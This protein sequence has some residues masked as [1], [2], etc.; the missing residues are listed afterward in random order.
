MKVLA[1]DT[2]SII[3]GVC[4]VVDDKV[5]SS[6]E[7]G[8]KKQSEEIV[9]TINKVLLDAKIT[10]DDIDLIAVS[11]GPA[12]FTSIRIGLACAKA[13]S[14]A[15][16]IPLI[17]IDSLYAIA[18][19]FEDFSGKIIVLM[20]AKMD[21][22][23]FAEFF[24]RDKILEVTHDSKLINI[25]DIKYIDF[26]NSLICGTAKNKAIKLSNKN[27]EKYSIS[28]NNDEKIFDK[29]GF[30]AINLY[31]KKKSEHNNPLYLRNPIISTRKK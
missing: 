19:K 3:S 14:L 10:M 5:I 2:T 29:L 24:C 30:V 1:I 12:S 11:K 7:I 22:F 31:S 23:F 18:S 25:N 28:D 27:Y 17:T 20:D 15:K 16:S 21:E 26:S 13:I 4:I 9:V 8:D 6:A